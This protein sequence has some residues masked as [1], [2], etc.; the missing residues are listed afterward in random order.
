MGIEEGVWSLGINI[1]RVPL[2]LE[3]HIY[4]WVFPKIWENP[5]IIHFNRVFHYKPSILGYPYFWKHPD[6][7]QPFQVPKME[8]LY[9]IRLFWVEGQPPKTEVSWVLGIYIYIYIHI[10][11]C[12]SLAHWKTT[13]TQKVHGSPHHQHGWKKTQIGQKSISLGLSENKMIGTCGNTRWWD[14]PSGG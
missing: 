6:I 4:I 14:P 10:Y 9:P 12:I 8:V 3:I 2:S 5:Q 1:G 13:T 7:H 11:S